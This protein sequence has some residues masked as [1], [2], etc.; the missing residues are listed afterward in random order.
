VIR[1]LSSAR[2]RFVLGLLGVVVVAVAAAVVVVLRPMR[3]TAPPADQTRPGPVLLVPGYGGSTTGLSVLADRLRAAGRDVTT[4]TVPDQGQGDLATQAAALGRQV[5]AALS[6][7]RAGSVDVV[8]YSAGG[9]VARL[10]AR[11]AASQA[12][13]IVTLG[14]PQHGTQLAELGALIPG[15]CPVAC[16]QLTP[17]SDLLAR[18]NQGDETPPGP[19]FVSIWTNHDQVVLPPDSA[20]L[21]G[22]LNIEVQSVCAGSTVDHTDLPSDPLVARMVA[23]ELEAGPTIALGANDC[24]RLSS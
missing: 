10:W 7:T 5:K 15:E 8:G 16:Q 20:V 19:E 17:G 4:V 18:L 23:A 2:R 21:A 14:S 3:S 11:G 22:A 6:R 12:R 24:S 1:S 9:V 13:H